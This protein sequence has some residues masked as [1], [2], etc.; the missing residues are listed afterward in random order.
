VLK[1]GLAVSLRSGGKVEQ[2]LMR[3]AFHARDGMSRDELLGDLWP[4][5]E[6]A[7]AAQSLNTLVSWV[8]R[9]LYNGPA[10]CALIVRSF[11][12]YRLNTDGGVRV[13]VLEFD[14]SVSAGDLR[15]RA[16]DRPGAISS[17]EQAV[18]LYT[19]DLVAASDVDHLIERER[20]RARYLRVLAELSEDW[21]TMGSYDLAL[22]EAYD[23]LAREPCREDAHRM[24][25]RC[26]VR[27]DQ[28]AQA[29][30]QY[31]L[32]RDVL[33]IEFGVA[34]ERTTDA[35]FDLIRSSPQSV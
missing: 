28:R 24:A 10:G 29:V 20:L 19:G 25:M 14:A 17:Y 21:F 32:C 13:D 26:F 4:S 27:M 5:A 16:G 31:R 15:A 2:M 6:L 7:L 1:G 18:A 35:L 12:R 8:N 9:T 30:R 22:S 33:A 3:L 34:P 11:G 23:L